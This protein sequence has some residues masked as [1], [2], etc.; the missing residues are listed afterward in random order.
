VCPSF[1][2]ASRAPGGWRP[3]FLSPTRMF[4]PPVDTSHT[5]THHS[6]RNGAPVLAVVIHATAGT[7]SL[8]WLVKNPRG[9]SSHALIR[10][11]GLIYELVPDDRAAHH[12]GYSQIRLNQRIYG[13]TTT[14]DANEITLG[15][16]LENLNNGKDPYPEE[17]ILALG[18]WLAQKARAYPNLALL[19]HEDIDTQGKSDPAGLTWLRIYAA[20]GVYLSDAPAPLPPVAGYT[21]DSPIMGAAPVSDD[22]L[23]AAFTLKCTAEGSPYGAE[24]E[25][26]I[27]RAIG[28]AYALEC[29]RAGVDLAIALAQCAHETGWLTSALSQ[30]HDRHGINLRNPAGIGVNGDASPGPA[31]GFAWDA[32]RNQYRRVVSF[33]SW[34]RSVVAHVGRLVAYATD[35]LKRTFPQAELVA[36]ALQYRGLPSEC[37]GSAPTLRQLGHGPNPRPGCGWAGA[38]DDQGH[39]YGRRVADA[40]TLLV[41]LAR[42]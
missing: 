26:P 2:G 4:I 17:Q 25:D 29:R 35:P 27:R 6:S 7:N 33:A 13:R 38:N 21:A 36:R 14:P 18:W 12:V 30:R 24:P 40:A 34:D 1:H 37:Q 19:K 39:D 5:S 23:I 32:D 9:V 15:V 41:E 28:P 10:K 3:V 42:T 22:A 31:P 8:G 20:M 16:E 11:D